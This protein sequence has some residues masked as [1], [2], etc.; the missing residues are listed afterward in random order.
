MMNI[1]D[2]MKK[3]NDRQQLSN[4]EEEYLVFSAS[5]PVLIRMML[6]IDKRIP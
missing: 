4:E 3:W 2:I 1:D 5:V 6:S